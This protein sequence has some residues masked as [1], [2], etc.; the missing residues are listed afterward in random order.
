VVRGQHVVHGQ[1][2]D[3]LAEGVGDGR[4][5]LL[6]GPGAEGRLARQAA[7]G[8][9]RGWDAFGFERVAELIATLIAIMIGIYMGAMPGN[10]WAAGSISDAHH[11]GCAARPMLE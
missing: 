6:V 4:V 5:A 9:D 11:S 10:L 8:V 7:R 2:E 3:A 1:R